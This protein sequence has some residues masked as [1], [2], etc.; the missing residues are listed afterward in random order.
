MQGCFTRIVQEDSWEQTE[1]GHALELLVPEL[2][3]D[4]SLAWRPVGIGWTR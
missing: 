4:R 2:K 1:D 3:Q